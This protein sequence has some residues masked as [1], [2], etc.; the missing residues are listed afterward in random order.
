MGK[1]WYQQVRQNLVQKEAC[2]MTQ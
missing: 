1:M 2:G